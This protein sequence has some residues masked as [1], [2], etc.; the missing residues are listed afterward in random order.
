MRLKADLLITHAK[1]ATL[2]GGT[3]PRRGLAMRQ[4]GFIDKGVV[5]LA[6]GKIVFA[7]T[8]TDLQSAEL[9]VQT[10][11]DAGGRLVTPGLIDAHT[12]LVHAGSREKELSLKLQG[13]PYLDILSQGGGILSTVRATQS[14]TEPQLTAQALVSLRHMLE[15]GTTTVEA[16]SGYGLNRTTELKQLRVTQALNG[17]QPVE[18]VSTFLGPHAL[19]PEYRDR[20][21]QFIDEMITLADEVWSLGLAEFADIFCERGVFSVAESRRYLTACRNLGY[22][23]KLHADEID[24]LGGTELAAELQALTVDHVVAASLDGLRAAAAAGVIAVLLPGTSWNLSGSYA[25][26]RFLMDVADGAVALATDYNPGSCPSESLQLI[27]AFAANG[28]HMTPEEILTAV[29]RNAAY[30]VGRGEKIG[31]L[32]AGWQADLCVW[33]TPEL[34]FLPYHFGVNHIHRVYKRGVLVVADGHLISGLHNPESVLPSHL[35]SSQR[36]V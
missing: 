18:L 30:A 26:A 22:G 5:A 8:E 33:E 11:W 12:H 34:A 27:M 14:A 32:E 25:K 17:L 2:A 1:L 15:H 13:V 10:V 28:L 24:A 35:D 23:L 6:A 31:R 9:E 7:G 29:T 4:V 36:S 20:S 3:G 19:P 16:K 21:H